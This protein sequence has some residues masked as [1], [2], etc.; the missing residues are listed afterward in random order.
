[1]RIK[2]S[3]TTQSPYIDISNR[4]KEVRIGNRLTQREFGKIVGLS[5]A[6]V[7]AIEAGLYTPNFNVLR[8]VHNR[9][10]VSYEYIIDGVKNDSSSVDIGK[11]KKENEMLKKVIE[12]MLK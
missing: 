11:L 4:M 6:A 7:G 3:N 5:A 8:I 1:M 10:N 12:K 9:F 2:K